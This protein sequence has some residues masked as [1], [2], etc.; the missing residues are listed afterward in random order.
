MPLGFCLAENRNHLSLSAKV[1]MSPKDSIFFKEI[2]D[3]QL[4]FPVHPARQYRQKK[5]D[6]RFQAG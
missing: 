6:L 3:D 5:H 1:E 4:L 2:F